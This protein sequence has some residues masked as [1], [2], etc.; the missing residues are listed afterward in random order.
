MK[1]LPLTSSFLDSVEFLLGDCGTS[2]VI[3]YQYVSHIVRR[4]PNISYEV[5]ALLERLLFV[6]GSLPP[7]LPG[8]ED[9][10]AKPRGTL[11]PALLG[12][13]EVVGHSAGNT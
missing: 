11:T 2:L 1:L 6:H 10:Y 5:A 13:Q 7:S 4:R 9:T 3:T 8:L 12:L